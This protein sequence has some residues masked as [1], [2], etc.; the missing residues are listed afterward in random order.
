VDEYADWCVVDLLDGKGVLAPVGAAHADETKLP[1]LAQLGEQAAL[2]PG[3]AVR[4]ALTT[5][6]AELFEGLAGERTRAWSIGTD[7]PNLLRQL[8]AHAAMVAPLSA[9]DQALGAITFGRAG[10]RPSFS[11]GDLAMAADLAHRVAFAIENARLYHE[12]QAAVRARDEFLSIASHELRTPLTPLE[13]GLQRLLRPRDGD[14]W[15]AERMRPA[16]ERCERQVRRLEVLIDNLLDVSRI[17]S[18]RLTLQPEDVDL[19]EVSREVAQRFADQISASGAKLEV[20]IA[21]P[22][23]GHWDRLRVEQV[24]TNL[25]TNAMKY[26]RGRPMELV[27]EGTATHGLVRIRDHGIGIDPDQLTRIFGRFERAVSARSYGGLGLG[28][29]IARQIVDAHGGRIEVESRPGEGSL[30]TIELPRTPAERHA[31]T[32]DHAQKKQ[33]HGPGAIVS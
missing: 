6:N 8:D 33:E 24:I 20:T 14:S 29:Y 7:V 21:G 26:G 28:L 2:D 17:S 23:V 3:S 30:F 13:I 5:G 19:G 18:G 10:G 31:A 22:V 11:E 12:A 25:L 4:V 27:C 16:L 9:R 1:V 32:G 15:P